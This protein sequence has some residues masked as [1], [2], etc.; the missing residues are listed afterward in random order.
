MFVGVSCWKQGKRRPQSTLSAVFVVRRIGTSRS[1]ARANA[2]VPS[3][4]TKN[5]SNRHR[6][7]CLWVLLVNNKG[8]ATFNL[9]C[10]RRLYRIGRNFAIS[11]TRCMHS[12]YRRS[13]PKDTGKIRQGYQLL[14]LVI[15]KGFGVRWLPCP[16]F[17]ASEG[18]SRFIPIWP[19]SRN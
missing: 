15:Y 9:H 14:A 7:C 18:P 13:G 4:D 19:I 2:F 12:R 6:Q 1:Y 3:R 5:R 16:L 11:R 10:Q 17:D 8:L